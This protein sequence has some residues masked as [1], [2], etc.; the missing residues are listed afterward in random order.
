M[1]TEKA[2]Q[3][4]KTTLDASLKAG[5]ISNIE[6]ASALI[7]ALAYIQNKLT[8]NDTGAN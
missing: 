8:S 2:L 1:S 6:H 7:Q 4:I 3:I 5:V